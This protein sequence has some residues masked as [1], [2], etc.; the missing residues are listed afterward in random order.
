MAGRCRK[1]QVLIKSAFIAFILLPRIPP[2]PTPPRRVSEK[3]CLPV[4]PALSG[5]KGSGSRN[6]SVE[7][8][9]DGRGEP[10]PLGLRYKKYEGGL[11]MLVVKRNGRGG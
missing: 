5:V 1:E 2:S 7:Q 10:V 8:A 9:E 3:V 4:L 11:G 6:L